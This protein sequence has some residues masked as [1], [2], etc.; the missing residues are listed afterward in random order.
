MVTHAG[1]PVRADRLRPLS[2]PRPIRVEADERGRPLA[3]ELPRGRQGRAVINGAREGAR[4]KEFAGV[5]AVEISDRWRIDDEWWRKEISRMY[6]RVVLA[7]GRI[8]TVFQDLIEGG[9]FLQTTATPRDS[10]EPLEVLTPRVAATTKL[11]AEPETHAGEPAQPAAP[12]RR[13]G[14]R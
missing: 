6:F 5:A 14:V 11:A 8:V 2:T 9:W 7:G 3:I 1:T 4:E 10:T 13:I 12:I